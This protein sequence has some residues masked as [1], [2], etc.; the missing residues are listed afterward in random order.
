MPKSKLR[1]VSV[2]TPYVY[3]A[4]S[5][6]SKEAST[7]RIARPSFLQVLIG[8]GTVRLRYCRGTPLALH[9]LVYQQQQ[10]Q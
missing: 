1:S 6:P 7:A 4:D 3:M 2:S 8:D 10:Q 5:T 9:W